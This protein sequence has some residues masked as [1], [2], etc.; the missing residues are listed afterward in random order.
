MQIDPTS[1]DLGELSPTARKAIQK[2]MEVNGWTL[3][4]TLNELG[5]ESVAKGAT[6]VVGRKKA[7]VLHLVPSLPTRKRASERDS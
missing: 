1:L 5:I 2:L 6:S 7:K 3:D 4:R